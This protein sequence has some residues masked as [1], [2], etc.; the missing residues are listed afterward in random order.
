MITETAAAA[1][2]S[3]RRK[4]F[5]DG[6]LE[7]VKVLEFRDPYSGGVQQLRPGR[8]RV[9]TDWWGYKK[10]P[11]LFM[12][13]NRDDTRTVARHRQALERT[14]RSI[15]RQ[16]GRRGTTRADTRTRPKFSLGPDRPRDRWRLP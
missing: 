9:S 12:P 14:R 4:K 2:P 6:M 1:L 13:V 11:E 3:T 16:L 10:H 8:D 15:E 7:P 5:G